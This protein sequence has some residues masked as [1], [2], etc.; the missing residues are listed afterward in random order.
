MLNKRCSN[1]ENRTMAEGDK[2]HRRG[3]EDAFVIPKINH[4]GKF[5]GQDA[6]RSLAII[7]SKFKSSLLKEVVLLSSSGDI[8]ILEATPYSD[9]YL[10]YQIQG[11]LLSR[12]QR[13]SKFIEPKKYSLEYAY[14]YRSKDE[15]TTVGLK[16]LHPHL[17]TTLQ[18]TEKEM[19]AVVYAFEKFRSYLIMNKSIV[20]TEHSALKF[21]LFNRK[22]QAR[23][24]RWVLTSSGI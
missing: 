12:N 22:R 23:L 14:F 16:E 3:N 5:L 6:S 15:F 4:G 24:L 1:G 20:Y 11:N 2:H 9:H 21:Y 13:I 10:L 18:T 19:L 8:L 7:E 17:E